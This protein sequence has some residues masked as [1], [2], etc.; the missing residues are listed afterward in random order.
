MLE[1]AWSGPNNRYICKEAANIM[2]DKISVPNARSKLAERVIVEPDRIYIGKEEDIK[3]GERVV[4]AMTPRGPR[5]SIRQYEYIETPEIVFRLRVLDDRVFDIG[6]LRI[7]LEY[8]QYF[9]LGANR[10]QGEG[11]FELVELVDIP[12]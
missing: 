5:S 3:I 4:H 7:L 6:H 12:C 1:T 9:G 11:K 8:A 10:S 2:R